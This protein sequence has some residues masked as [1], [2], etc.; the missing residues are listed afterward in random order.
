MVVSSVVIATSLNK[1]SRPNTGRE[2][3]SRGSTRFMPCS[4]SLEPITGLSVPHT[5]TGRRL[6]APAFCFTLA[7]GFQRCFWS[8]LST[9]SLDSLSET[10]AAY[11]SRSKR[12]I[13][14]IYY[15]P[16][17]GIVKPVSKLERKDLSSHC[18]RQPILETLHM[19]PQRAIECDRP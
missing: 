5:C 4:I 10:G 9:I 3:D 12:L 6:S 18:R 2:F 15:M 11:S 7:G 14:S 16:L 1:N 19:A 8:R 13:L 17:G